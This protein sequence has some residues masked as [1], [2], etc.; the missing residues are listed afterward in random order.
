MS[1]HGAGP[2]L[3]Y[4]IPAYFFSLGL[5]SIVVINT[6]WMCAAFVILCVLVK[7]D[8]ITAFS[9]ACCTSMFLPYLLYAPSSMSETACFSL[10]IIY[11]ALLFKISTGNQKRYPVFMLICLLVLSVYRINH[12]VLFLPPILL[13][14]SE[15]RKRNVCVF[16]IGGVII[17]LISA[18]LVVYC[19]SPYPWGHLYSVFQLPRTE[20]IKQIIRYGMEQL[21]SYVSG[22][23]LWHDRI[24]KLFY[25]LETIVCVTCAVYERIKRR[26]FYYV[27][28][29]T[30]L[31]TTVLGLSAM[32]RVDARSM[33]PILFFSL[34][35]M[36][37]WNQKYLKTALLCAEFVILFTGFTK[38]VYTYESQYWSTH[39][40]NKAVADII[41]PPADDELLAKIVYDRDATSRWDNT[42]YIWE[43][44]SHRFYCGLP[45][46]IGIVSGPFPEDSEE[47]PKWLFWTEAYE[48][49]RYTLIYSD[50]TGYLYQRAR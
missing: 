44:G 37:L 30:V 8:F 19:Q 36:V 2:F 26:G 14:S 1:T 25:L 16:V 39:Y 24:Y 22:G 27:S 34:L 47:I 31:I 38:P 20:A 32:Y 18:W 46:G 42:I 45:K 41:L 17:F 33:M 6:C 10:M 28:M 48:D 4:G 3:L 12:V 7:P 9:I 5:N 13:C 40:R 43:A 50:E 15:K 49:D 35:S 11:V 21:K 23:D 29:S